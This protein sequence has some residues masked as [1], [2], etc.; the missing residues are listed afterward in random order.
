MNEDIIRVLDSKIRVLERFM[1]ALDDI[2]E[3]DLYLL[4]EGSRN[5][6]RMVLGR[7]RALESRKEDK[8]RISDNQE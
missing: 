2:G 5:R 8:Q 1:E 3:D 4:V 7:E 6:Y